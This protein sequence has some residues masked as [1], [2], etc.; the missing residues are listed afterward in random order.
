MAVQRYPM[1][2]PAPQGAGFEERYWSPVNS[3]V[4][5]ANGKLAYIIHRVEDVT[6]FVRFTQQEGIGAEDQTG[7]ESG[8]PRMEAEILLRSKE[9]HELNQRLRQS[10][11]R[12]QAVNRELDDFATIVSHDLK[13]PLR[14]VGMV[15]ERVQSDYA[16]QL[17]EQGHVLL[18]QIVRRVARMDRMIDGI[19]HYSRLG[20]TEENPEPVGLAE[21][22]PGV[23]EDLAPPA[24]AQV[25]IAPGL[26]VLYGEPVR[27]HQ[28]FQNLISNAIK[29]SDKPQ[30][31]IQVE[32]ADRGPMWEF[33]VADNGPGIEERFFERIFKIFQTLAPKDK[34]DS[35][36]VGLALVQ[37]IVESAGGRVWVESRVGEGSTFRFTWPK[38]PRAAAAQPLER[39]AA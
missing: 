24:R 28:L 3:P 19:L 17:D 25:H 23:V 39:V 12:L 13:S 11:E 27:L 1:R 15:A 18:A 34:T 7:L 32:W 38:G 6:E 29:H 8:V 37:R 16:D 9:L 14:V 35:T 22:V 36:G 2:R 26:P 31:E 5:G 4:L 20:R 21:L 30:I 10:E 33:S